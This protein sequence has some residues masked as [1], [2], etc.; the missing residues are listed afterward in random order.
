MVRTY[1]YVRVAV[2][3]HLHIDTKTGSPTLGAAML[4]NA[5]YRIRRQSEDVRMVILETRQ[6][7]HATAFQSYGFV[8]DPHDPMRLF[9]RLPW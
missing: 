4:V 2:I 8:P 1:P 3:N 7:S 5:L 9:G 6:P